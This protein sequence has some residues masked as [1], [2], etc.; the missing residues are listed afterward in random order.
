V[1]EA[2]LKPLNLPLKVLDNTVPSGNLLIATGW[3]FLLYFLQ[4]HNRNSDLFSIRSHFDFFVILLPLAHFCGLSLKYDRALDVRRRRTEFM[5][6][7]FYRYA[8][9]TKPKIDSHLTTAALDHWT[10]FWIFA[11]AIPLVLIT[12]G[13][14]LFYGRVEWCMALLA[15]VLVLL[16]VLSFIHRQ[17]VEA[18]LVQLDAIASDPAHKKEILQ[19]FSELQG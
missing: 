11:E 16:L 4:L 8:S 15:L 6:K 9:G 19:T 7:I 2:A 13:V 18:A 14:L 3:A 12:A 5:R 10:N 1:V 17:C